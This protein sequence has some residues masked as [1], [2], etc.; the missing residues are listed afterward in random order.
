MP[1]TSATVVHAF[2]NADGTPAS[3]SIT[4]VLSGRMTQ[5]GKT[6][7]AGEITTNLDATGNLSQGLTSNV[8]AATVPQS[9]SWLM[10]MRIQG[11]ETESFA[12]VVPSGGGTVDLATLLP[13]QPLGF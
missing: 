13:Q 3:G 5:T 4:F 6:I 12:I 10:T 8:D 2:E 1:F 7:T 11:A 9:T